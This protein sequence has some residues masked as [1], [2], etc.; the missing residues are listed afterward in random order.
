[1][2][3]METALQLYVARLDR[4]PRVIANRAPLRPC[5]MLFNHEGTADMRRAVMPSGGRGDGSASRRKLS[6]RCCPIRAVLM[7]GH[8]GVFRRGA[9]T[10]R[11]G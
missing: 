8:G 11:P 4:F 5:Y 6:A 7:V 1:V 3:E 10:H 9:P 2:V